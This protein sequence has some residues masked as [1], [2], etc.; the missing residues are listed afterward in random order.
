MRGHVLHAAYFLR[1][2]HAYEDRLAV[3]YRASECTRILLYHK[4]RSAANPRLITEYYAEE[5]QR[6]LD[7]LAAS[8]RT[9]P[10]AARE[11]R[12]EQGR[13]NRHH[14]AEMSRILGQQPPQAHQAA[15][16]AVS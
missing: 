9:G 3:K 14:D 7:Y 10:D 5:N 12:E 16:D 15:R 4:K 13:I 2:R 1:I 11:V 6:Y 8:L